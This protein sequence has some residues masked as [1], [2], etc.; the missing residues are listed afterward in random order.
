MSYKKW[1]QFAGNILAQKMK[2]LILIH[3]FKLIHQPAGFV[4]IQPVE[5]QLNQ[6]RIDY[7]LN[8]KTNL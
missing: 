2:T 5:R 7:S 4:E 6:T 8:G 1:H 3:R